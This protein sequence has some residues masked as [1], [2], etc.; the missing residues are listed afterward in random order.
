M[1]NAKILGVGVATLDIYLDRKRMYPGGNEYN[2]ACNARSLGAEAGFLGVFGDD[3][4]GE[5]LETTLREQGVD[6]SMCRHELGSSGYSLVRLKPDGDRVFLD[7]NKQGVTD[8]H[9]IEFTEEELDYVRNYDV[10]C[11]GRCAS[12]S[13][14][15]IQ[16][17]H[18]EGIKICY[19]FHAIY[20]D[21]TIKRYSPYITYAFF[22]SSHLTL[23]EIRHNLKLACDYGVKVAVATRG[24]DSVIAYDGNQFY[25]QET[26]KVTPLDALGAGDSYIAAFLTNYL[27]L[28]D[29][30]HTQG[31]LIQTSLANAAKHSASVVMIE[32]SIGVGFDLEDKKL[33]DLINLDQ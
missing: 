12:V 28:K 24:A 32:G 18:E 4:A 30:G 29:E 20:S 9:P 23:E 26:E 10:V 6:V 27:A 17:L 1:K 11:V 31:E 7:W 15:K 16:R 33:D 3:L 8:L 13:Y 5:I 19:D 22:S 21:N 2:V 14:R 25:E